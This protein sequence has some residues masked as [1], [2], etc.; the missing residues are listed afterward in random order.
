[1]GATRTI[2]RILDGR[3]STGVGAGE[4]RRGKGTFIA[5]ADGLG[6]AAFGHCFGGFGVGCSGGLWMGS[7]HESEGDVG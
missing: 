5:F 1:M 2:S 6:V 4:A 3:V 7:G